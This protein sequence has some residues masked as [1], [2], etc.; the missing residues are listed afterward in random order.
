MKKRVLVLGATGFVGRNMAEYFAQKEDVT[1][2]GTYY[3]SAPLNHPNIKMVCTDLTVKQDVARVM[4]NQDLV[5]QAAAVTSGANDIVNNP[6]Y[7]IADN[8][9]MNSLIFRA[10]FDSDTPHVIF[11]SC[12][13]MYHPSETP[14]KESDF[15]PGR[16]L[17]D[18]YFGGAWNKIYFEKMCEFYARQGRNRYTVIRHSN[19]YGPYDKFDLDKG[20]V[21][22]ATVAK[23]MAAPDNGR[24]VIWGSGEEKRDLLHIDDL[25]R[26][27]ESAAEV[28]KA[29]FALYNAG[30]GLPIAVKDL[31]RKV[32]DASGKNIEL[33][34]DLSKP[35]IPIT[36]CLDSTKAK[37][38]LG[39]ESQISID[40]GI[41]RTLQW[42]R[43]HH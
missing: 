42:Y 33:D 26:M 11:F 19:N 8:A 31:V 41:R 43:W 13:V 37:A 12:S 5:L 40:E 28:Q 2:T 39:W 15:D 7:H 10:A 27:V 32:C 1:V 22:G 24:I 20:H 9:V 25:V 29:P 35:T 38:D 23:V 3:N 4:Q 17:H 30:S 18:K 21:F 14:L 34:Y 16:P 6:H 36:I